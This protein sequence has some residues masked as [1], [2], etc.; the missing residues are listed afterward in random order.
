M[1]LA[2]DLWLRGK[3]A[4][5]SMMHLMAYNT[6]VAG[7]AAIQAWTLG[8]SMPTGFWSALGRAGGVELRVA[9]ATPLRPA[10]LPEPPADAAEVSANLPDGPEGDLAGLHLLDAPR[11]GRADDLTALTGIGQKL[12]A[13]LHEAGIYHFDQLARLD[14]DSVAWLNDRQP[15]FAMICARHKLVEQARAKLS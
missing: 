1:N 15:G 2:E 6:A 13:A 9:D 5:T 10:P 7:T 8:L 3:A 12:G 11:G 14:P 4:Q